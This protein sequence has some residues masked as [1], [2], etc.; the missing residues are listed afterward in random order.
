MT[1]KTFVCTGCGR[2]NAVPEAFAEVCTPLEVIASSIKRAPNG[3]LIT[4][5]AVG[6]ITVCTIVGEVSP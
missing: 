5:T 1:D 2:E 3:R 6:A 4:A